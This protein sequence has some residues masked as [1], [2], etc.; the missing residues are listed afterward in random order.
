MGNK[1]GKP[2]APGAGV[3]GL[4]GGASAAASADAP[5]EAPSADVDIE[6]ALCTEAAEDS[7]PDKRRIDLGDFELLKVRSERAEWWSHDAR[8]RRCWG[9]GRSA[10]CCW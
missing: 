9:R 5:S 1:P 10:R 8:V 3:D 2:G 7:G 4:G 6:D